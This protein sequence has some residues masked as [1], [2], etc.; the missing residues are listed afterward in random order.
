MVNNL[1]MPFVVKAKEFFNVVDITWEAQR[2]GRSL[3]H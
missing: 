2:F 1:R 3:L